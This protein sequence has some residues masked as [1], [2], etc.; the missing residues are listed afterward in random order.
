MEYP[1][2]FLAATPESLKIPLAMLIVIASARLLDEVCEHM[3]QPGLVG[4]IPAG[5]V[6]PT[7]VRS[8]RS[9]NAFARVARG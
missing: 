4:Q 2:A 1:I 9:V 7:C 8:N 5:A 3:N 6:M